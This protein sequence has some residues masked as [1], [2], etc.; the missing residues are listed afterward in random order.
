MHLRSDFSDSRGL[1]AGLAL[2]LCLAHGAGCRPKPGTGA[3]LQVQAPDE[4]QD[5][6]VFVDGNYIGQV[7]ALETAGVPGLKL[8]PGVHRVEIR[9]PGRFPVQKTVRVESGGPATVVVDA[10]LL[11]DPS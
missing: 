6:D 11:T 8:A 4:D 3:T 7:S 9:K 2:A 5:A 10:E 1:V